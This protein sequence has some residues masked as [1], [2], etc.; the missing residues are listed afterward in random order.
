MKV[1]HTIAGLASETGG[2]ARSVPTLCREL[3]HLGHEVRLLGGRGTLP[4]SAVRTKE[5]VDLRLQPVGPRWMGHYSPPF[6]QATR[7]AAAWADIVHTHGLWL[8]PNSA[9]R[10]A[11]EAYG[12]PFVVSPRGMLSKPAL[13]QSRRRKALAW[14]AY[15][16]RD[17]QR[18]SLVHVTSP[19]ELMDLRSLGISGPA[20]IIPNGVDL[21]SYPPLPFPASQSEPQVLY[22]SRIHPLKGI[23]LLLRVWQGR[24]LGGLGTLTVAGTGERA[25]VARLESELRQMG[26]PSIRYVGEVLETAKQAL[27]CEASVVVLPSASENYAMVV[28]EALASARPVIATQGAPWGDLRT[29]DC[30]WWVSGSEHAIGAALEDALRRS[31]SELRDMGLRGRALAE[32]R[33]CAHRAAER[34]QAVYHWLC[35]QGPAPETVDSRG[36]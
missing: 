11:A 31:S 1:V 23:D 17:L 6:T 30:G 21:D 19:Q 28:A 27:L 15:Q 35:G 13:R 5:R 3:A 2:P 8:H 7:R 25:H 33:H 16:R 20:A 9:S 26:D 36:R 10:R 14:R 18:A 12:K 4:P 34:M 24:K 22:L 32:S 29:H